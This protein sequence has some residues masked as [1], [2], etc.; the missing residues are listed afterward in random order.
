MLYVGGWTDWAK[1]LGSALNISQSTVRDGHKEYLSNI[2][3][4]DTVRPR[5]PNPK[6]SERKVNPLE[7]SQ[8]GTGTPPLHDEADGLTPL[9]GEPPTQEAEE[10]IALQL[11]QEL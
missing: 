4:A 7:G 1:E 5:G 2:F 6:D 10:D 9:L 3:A 11:T 8:S